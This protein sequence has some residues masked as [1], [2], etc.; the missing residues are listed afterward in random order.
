MEYDK[1][2]PAADLAHIRAIMEE[3]SRAHPRSGLT[4]ILVGAYALAGSGAAWFAPG[5]SPA[6]FADG[7]NS[8]LPLSS[9][10]WNTIALA[11]CVFLLS[12]STTIWLAVRHARRSGSSVLTP[13]ARLMLLHAGI[14]LLSG[15]AVL[16][17][18]VF[19]GKLDLLIP[20]SLIF[21]GLALFS[22]SK[23]TFKEASM[24]GLAQV[25]CGLAAL[26]FPAFSVVFWMLGFGLA[27]LLYGAVMHN[28]YERS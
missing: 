15:G 13:A 14:P 1:T 5:F 18:F 17:V 8:S 10:E 16:S 4:A 6:S 28:R 12:V 11:F 9:A 21:Y 23:F 22:A 19:T 24:L 2:E 20:F 3:S 27:H 25:V 7:V 26:V